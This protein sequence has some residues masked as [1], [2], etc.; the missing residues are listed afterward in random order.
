MSVMA[1][2]F[3]RGDVNAMR[4][5]TRWSMTASFAVH[6]MLFAWLLLMPHPE[7]TQETL[8]EISFLEGSDAATAAAA[9][10]PAAAPASEPGVLVPETETRHFRRESR[11]ADMRPD[12]QS[13]SSADDRIAARLATLQT[14]SS[15]P[16]SGVT[17]GAPSAMW[18]ATP[19]TPGTGVGG[20]APVAMARGGGGGSEPLPLVRGT[21]GH[22]L[23]PAMAP[24]PAV[25]HSEASRPAEEGQTT[26]RRT[27][28]G[29]TL[30]GPIADRAVLVHVAPDYPEW[31]KKEAVEGSVTLYFVVR[32]DGT[33]KENVLVQKTAGFGDFDDNARTALRAWRF[34]PLREGRTGEQWGTITFRFRIRDG[35]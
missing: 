33:I 3:G 26:A 24:A 7:A 2:P 11:S 14:R 9:A 16:S 17:V 5:R 4:V 35:G 34:E 29:A 12:P 13:E 25:E 10:A 15:A 8:T 23:S 21:G 28:A 31:A 1:L 30:M 20:T 6:A 19:A 27:L 18:N 22:A 32:P